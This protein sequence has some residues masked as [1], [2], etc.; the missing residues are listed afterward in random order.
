MTNSDVVV[1]A[2]QLLRSEAGATPLERVRAKAAFFADEMTLRHHPPLPADGLIKGAEL[3]RVSEAEAAAI[4]RVVPDLANVKLT[5]TV[6]GSRVRVESTD[7]GTGPSGEPIELRGHVL[8]EVRGGRI[9]AMDAH[10]ED[11]GASR[12]LLTELLATGGFDIPP[13]ARAAYGNISADT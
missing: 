3:A 2:S 13:E 8:I 9:V 7:R 10:W 12:T 1:V 11:D 6:E 4:C 5:M